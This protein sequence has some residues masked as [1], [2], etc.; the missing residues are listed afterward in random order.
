MYAV[1]IQY[2]AGV[3]INTVR[4][5][6]KLMYSV[7]IDIKLMYGVRIDIELMLL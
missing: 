2:R 5:D 7:R 6:I 4:L 3:V 1:R